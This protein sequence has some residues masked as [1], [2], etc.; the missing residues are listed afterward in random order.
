[1]EIDYENLINLS[2]K[3]KMVIEDASLEDEKLNVEYMNLN[4]IIRSARKILM[5]K[6]DNVAD[7][8]L[9]TSVTEENL[10]E[11]QTWC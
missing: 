9:P 10:E 8:P 11:E 3:R 4:S 2:E 5:G 6:L 1:M 7:T